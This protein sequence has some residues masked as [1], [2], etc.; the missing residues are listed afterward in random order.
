MLINYNPQNSLH[1][2]FILFQYLLSNQ[3]PNSTRTTPALLCGVCLLHPTTYS[4]ACI[5]NNLLLG[6]MFQLL[7]TNA[8]AHLICSSLVYVLPSHHSPPSSYSF[9]HHLSWPTTH[10]P[11]ISHTSLRLLAVVCPS[12]YYIYYII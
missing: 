5:Y 4:H 6:L 3:H 11:H 7:S 1:F 9:Y 2:H 8:I 10:I 12:I